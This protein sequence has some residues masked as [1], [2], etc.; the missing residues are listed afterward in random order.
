MAKISNIYLI[1]FLYGLSLAT[2][3]AQSVKNK[4]SLINMI[5]AE[6]YKNPNQVI[7]KAQKIVEESGNDIDYKI[8]AYKL[9][10]DAFSSKRDYEK[11][12]EYINKANNLL[13]Y[14]NDDLLKIAIINKIAIQYHQLKVYDK[15]IQYLDLAEQLILKYPIKD[16]I[17]TVLGKNY[18]V[19]GFIYK[20]KLNC[21]IA[22]DYFNKGIIELEKSK[23]KAN[24]A[25]LSIAKYNKGNCYMLMLNNEKANESFEQAIVNAKKINAKS[26]Q[27]FALK[28]L[29]KVYTLEGN[30]K[31]SINT[32][33]EA[34][35]IS[36]DVNDLILNQELFSGLSDNYLA[37]N[38]WENYK[39]YHTKYL[40]TQKLI[41]VRERKSISESLLEKKKELNSKL[42]KEITLLYF[43]FGF[44][45]VLI[46]VIILLFLINRKKEKKKIAEL[47]F[48]IQK[49]QNEKPIYK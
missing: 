9:I 11:S 14:S 10:S 18:V 16:S 3:Y 31:E 1:I 39:I 30:Y 26:L 37:I 42:K 2:C 17:Y 49:I 27:A 28:G 44:I 29:A 41:K 7:L 21:D 12:L 38:D 24:N 47:I 19:R 35:H 15:A 20:E 22:I 48:Q 46:F 23:L 43:S 45:I 5:S 36:S 25:G 13:K 32:L 40:T 33:N 4:D 34:N 6:I 8:K